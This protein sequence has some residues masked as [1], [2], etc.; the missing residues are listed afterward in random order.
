[1]PYKDP[2]VRLEFCRKREARRRQQRIDAGLN[3]RG[4]E[5]REHFI[6]SRRQQP[7]TRTDEQLDREAL[8]WLE[9]MGV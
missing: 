3:S 6:P 5:R 9:R 8:S 1:M 4:A 7:V 2:D